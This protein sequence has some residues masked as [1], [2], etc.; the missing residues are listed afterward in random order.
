M[1]LG[2]HVNEQFVALNYY[3]VKQIGFLVV[4]IFG[5]NNDEV[6]AI[7]IG[8][9]NRNMLIDDLFDKVLEII[10]KLID[11]DG[12]HYFALMIINGDIIK[13]YFGT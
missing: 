12:V 9:F 4:P 1:V 10:F 8:N 5:T 7:L 2:S 3:F 11:G 6:L 13:T